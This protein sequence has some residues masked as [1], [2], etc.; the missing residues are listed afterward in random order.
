MPFPFFPPSVLLTHVSPAKPAHPVKGSLLICSLP[1]IT[2]FY[3]QFSTEKTVETTQSIN[4]GTNPSIIMKYFKAPK[5]T[6]GRYN[7]KE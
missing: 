1:L 2:P 6:L 5:K 4:Q 3:T 7:G